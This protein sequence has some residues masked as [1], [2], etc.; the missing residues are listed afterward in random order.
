MT[1]M[2]QIIYFTMWL[3]FT[4]L[5]DGKEKKIAY[6][7]EQTACLF[8]SYKLQGGSQCKLVEMKNEK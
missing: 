3:L 4:P 1:E 7:N 2:G 5:P 8:A 6:Y